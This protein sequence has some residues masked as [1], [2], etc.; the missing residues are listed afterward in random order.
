MDK[1]A[2]KLPG[3]QEVTVPNA[4]PSN[5]KGDFSISGYALIQLIINS[6]FLLIIITSLV[7]MLIAGIRLIT[8]GG[9]VEVVKKARKQ[10]IYA[11]VGLIVATLAFFLIRTMIT[12]L[13]GNP[14]FWKLN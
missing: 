4:I 2:F 9:E 8:S 6:L 1:I 11:I 14:S 7:F 3:G 5:L 12:I 13:G 10:I